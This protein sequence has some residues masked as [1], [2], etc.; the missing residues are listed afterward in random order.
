[1]T[2]EEFQAKAL[3]EAQSKLGENVTLIRAYS[4]R[5]TLALAENTFEKHLAI[6]IGEECKYLLVAEIG[7]HDIKC[8]PFSK[9]DSALALYCEIKGDTRR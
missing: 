4:S 7:K 3:K 5:E 9:F 8:V 1:M 2:H 6:F